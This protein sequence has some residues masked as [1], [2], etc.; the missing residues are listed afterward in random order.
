MECR[1]RESVLVAPSSAGACATGG[2]NQ[3]MSTKR[4]TRTGPR[5]RL[6][7][8]TDLFL[9]FSSAVVLFV[10]LALRFQDPPWLRYACVSSA[11]L[12]CLATGYLFLILRVRKTRV[13][14]LKSVD[15]R[16]ADV[17]GYLATYLLP[18]AVVGSPNA[19]DIAAY[20]LILAAV[21]LVYVRSNLRF[22]NPT[23]Y[24]LGFR[25]FAMRTVDGFEGYLLSKRDVK[26][27]DFVLANERGRFMLD[28]G[29]WNAEGDGS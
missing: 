18:V 27:D 2:Q 15:D 5:S 3:L 14:H 8:L 28:R 20:A 4:R 1:S 11:A 23:L 16:G 22:V 25:L 29:E 19:A 21:A 17:G 24:V 7:W 6:E 26:A 13:V 9:F 12:G 10:G